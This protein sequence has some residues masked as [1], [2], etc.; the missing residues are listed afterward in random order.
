MADDEF[1]KS[2]ERLIQTTPTNSSRFEAPYIVLARLR[3]LS[4]EPHRNAQIMY[5]EQRRHGHTYR[6]EPFMYMTSAVACL[7]SA[8]AN[9]VQRVTE[10][11]RSIRL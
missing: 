8:R 3:D 6:S 11:L 5:V 4:S 7:E 10:K 9:L 1:L 2:V